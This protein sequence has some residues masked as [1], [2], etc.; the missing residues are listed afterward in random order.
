MR[1]IA[2]WQM[3]QEHRR[4]VMRR[5]AYR[6]IVRARRV[7]LKSMRRKADSQPKLW[8][9]KRDKKYWNR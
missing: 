3:V 4:F 7:R 2:K 8:K 6:K 1:G 9:I 5:E